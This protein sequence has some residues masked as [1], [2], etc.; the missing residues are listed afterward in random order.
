MREDFENSA[1]FILHVCPYTKSKSSAKE[2]KLPIVSFAFLKNI[3]DSNSGVDFRWHTH[4]GYN[5]LNKD[6]KAELYQWQNTKEGK[7]KIDKYRGNNKNTG[8]SNKSR[9]QMAAQMKSL[10]SRLKSKDNDNGMTLEDDNACI[11][12]AMPTPRK[13]YFKEPEPLIVAAQKLQ[14]IMKRKRGDE[15]IE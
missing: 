8:G 15:D 13:V 2:N 6:Q 11:K 14:K 12:A 1:V 5:K 9:K 4:V 10:Q 7:D 3:S